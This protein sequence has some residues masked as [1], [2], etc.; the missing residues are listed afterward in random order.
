MPGRAEYVD[1]ASYDH[2]RRQVIALGIPS[3]GMVS[4]RWVKSFYEMRMPTN[5]GVVHFYRE[6]KEVGDAR[7]EIVASAFKWHEQNPDTDML[8]VFFLDDDVLPHPEAFVKLV[9][10]ERTIVS[11]LYFMKY[12]VPTP[13]VLREEGHGTVSWRPGEIVECDAH[14]MGLTFVAM[15]VF[16][17]LRDETELGVDQYGFPAW[18]KTVKDK[19]VLDAH[20]RTAITNYTEDVYFLQRAKALGYQPAVDTSAQAFGWHWHAKERR[21]YPLKQWTEYQETGRISWETENGDVVAW[22]RAS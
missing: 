11:G 8:G 21:A 10:L 6:G 14:G 7:N 4:L 3:L 9:S 5:R 22:E 20:G 19:H 2:K 16:R 15:E 1:F 12:Q 17:R 18:F 13:L